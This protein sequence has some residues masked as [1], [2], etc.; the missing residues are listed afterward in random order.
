[1]SEH[2]LFD[3]FRLVLRVPADLDEAAC[4]SIRHSLESRPF[5]TGL[6]RVLRQFL[7]RYPELTPVRVRISG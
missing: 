7:R 5:R 6:R 2:V 3:E 4:D 1:M